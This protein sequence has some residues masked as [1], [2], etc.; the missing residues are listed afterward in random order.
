MHPRKLVRDS[1]GFAASQF[2]VRA[3]MIARTVLAARWLGPHA[4]G[5]WNALQLIMDYGQLAQLGTQQ[6]LDQ[7]VPRRIVDGDAER[8]SRL[9]RAGFTSITALSLM[10]CAGGVLYFARSTGSLVQTWGVLGMSLAMGIVLLINWSSYHTSLLR[11]HGNIGAVSRWF[12]LQ[13]MI[14]ALVGLALIRWIGVWGLLWGWTAGTLAAFLWTRWEGRAFVPMR[15]LV[16]SDSVAL[17][18]IGFPMFFFV[19]TSIINRSLDRLIILRY[20]GTRELG[21]YSLAVTAVTLLMYLPDSATYVFYPRLLQR[22]RA[23][24]DRPEEIQAP[25]IG[26][27][28]LLGVLTPALGGLACLAARDL[29]QVAVPNFL[30]GATPVRIMCFTATAMC[31]ANLASIVMMT[32]GRQF[33]LM[34][35][36]VVSTLAFAIAD[37]TV[38]RSGLGINGVAWATL[39]TYAVSAFTLLGMALSSLRLGFGRAVREIG[40]A[41]W[42]LGAAMVLSFAA[43]KLAPGGNSM[44]VGRRVLHLL[45]GWA[46]F[47][48]AYGLAVTPQLRGLGFRQLVSEFNLPFASWLKRDSDRPAS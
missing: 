34:P 24:G 17:F 8:L 14:G 21:F 18:R 4:F 3:A 33:W 6:G 35:V 22:F 39:A 11:S 26:V 36:A 48:A 25:V 47:L 45:L 42:G 43:E 15:P 40:F 12:F 37:I 30:L 19:G 1:I 41:A 28:R 32:L 7:M 13:G 27:L 44:E 9:K 20:L 29:I 5:A 10:F 38:L 23:A 2:A 46:T 16:S 31:I